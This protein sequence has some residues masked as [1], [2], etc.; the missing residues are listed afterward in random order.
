MNL[1]NP[2]PTSEKNKKCPVCKKI[3]MF[4][5]IDVNAS[6]CHVYLEGSYASLYCCSK[7]NVVI[8]LDASKEKTGYDFFPEEKRRRR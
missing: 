2:I 7:C 6:N 8:C 3:T 5:R 1:S 4:K